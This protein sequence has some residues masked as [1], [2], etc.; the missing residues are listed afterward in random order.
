MAYQS[1]FGSVAGEKSRDGF[2]AETSWFTDLIEDSARTRKRLNGTEA[3]KFDRYV[4]GL[5]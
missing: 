5:R 2:L 1:I 4:D 3:A